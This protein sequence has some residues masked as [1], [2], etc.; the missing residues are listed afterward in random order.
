MDKEERKGAE[1]PGTITAC[2]VPRIELII[3]DIF[4]WNSK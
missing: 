3:N 4:K 2:N 1:E